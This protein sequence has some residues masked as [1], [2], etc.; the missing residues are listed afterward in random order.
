LMAN[1]TSS[2][3][4]SNHSDSN[5]ISDGSSTP[6]GKIYEPKNILITGGA[7]FIGSHLVILLVKKYPNYNIINFDKLEYCASLEYL[8]EIENYPNYKFVKGDILSLD[9]LNYVM[10][11]HKIDTVIHLAA[12]SHVDLSFLNS[13]Y[14]TRVN[15]MGTHMLLEASRTAGVRRFIHVSTDE[16]YGETSYNVDESTVLQPS[17]PYAASKAGAELVVQS[18]QRCFK[19][20]TIITRGNNVYGPHQF[21]E[22]VIPKFVMRLKNGLPCCLHGDGSQKRNYVYVEDVVKAF[23]IILHRGV[24]GEIYNIG[25]E[26]QITNLELAKKLISLFNKDEAKNIEFVEDRPFNDQ[27]YL[28]DSRKLYNLGWKTTISFDEG[29]EKTVKWIMDKTEQCWSISTKDLDPHPTRV[30]SLN[31]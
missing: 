23:E 2:P 20:P 28:I 19:F 31:L 18:Y 25:T 16:V 5:G 15:V 8:K 14:F 11:T 3:I 21:P 24:I 13:I 17:N 26:Q 10:L 7:G 12:Q 4:I 1:N 30:F 9:L 22:K 27:R 6:H 29:L